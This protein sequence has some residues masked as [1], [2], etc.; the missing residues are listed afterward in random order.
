MKSE[1][2]TNRSSFQGLYSVRAHARKQ[3]SSMVTRKPPLVFGIL[4]AGNIPPGSL[5]QFIWW[6]IYLISFHH[7]PGK[8]FSWLPT[9]SASCSCSSMKSVVDSLQGLSTP[10]PEFSPGQTKLPI[11]PELIVLHLKTYVHEITHTLF[12]IVQPSQI[13]T[14][15][16]VHR[17]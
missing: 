2:N 6:Y 4:M 3:T 11:M 1:W 15:F 13:D 16:L 5:Y 9:G 8:A 10:L 12:I 17:G 7:V 14:Y